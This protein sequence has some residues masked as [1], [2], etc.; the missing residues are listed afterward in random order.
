M[1][2]YRHMA[3]AKGSPVSLGRPAFAFL[4]A[5][6]TSWSLGQKA[7]KSLPNVF[8][9]SVGLQERTCLPWFAGR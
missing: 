3:T 6:S 7:Q 2:A 4:G 5:V 8:A 9:I 1:Y